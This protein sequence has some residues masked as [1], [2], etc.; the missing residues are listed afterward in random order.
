MTDTNVTDSSRLRIIAG[1]LEQDGTKAAAAFLRRLAGDME[2]QS[3]VPAGYVLAPIHPTKE[4]REAGAKIGNQGCD[5]AHHT[6][7]TMLLHAPVA[8]QH[9]ETK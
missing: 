9:T 2:Q 1:W 4:M 6:W 5:F 7:H 3:A 8:A